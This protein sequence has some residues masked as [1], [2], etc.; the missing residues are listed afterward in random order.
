MITQL[1]SDQIQL[2]KNVR[3]RYL[4]R[5]FACE[6]N[7]NKAKAMIDFIY[8]LAK[9]PNPIKIILDSPL[10]LQWGANLLKNK[11]AQV[12][13]QVGAQVGD[14]VETQVRA[15]VRAQVGDQKLKYFDFAYNA[16]T[17]DLNWIAFYDYFEQLKIVHHSLFHEYKSLID[18]N[19]F[20]NIEF[21]KVCLICRPPKYIKRDAQNRLHCENGMAIE[22]QDGWGLYYLHGRHFTKEE[23]RQFF[24]QPAT[25][26]ATKVLG[27][28]NVEQRA[29][30]IM[31]YGFEQMLEYLP[32]VK[33]IHTCFQY[34]KP[35]ETR[36]KCWLYQFDFGNLTHKLCIMPNHTDGKRY[37]ILVDPNIQTCQEAIAWHFD[38]TSEE[39][40]CI[41]ET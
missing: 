26:D 29:V 35:L 9:K 6:F 7:E 33:L 25:I 12:R 23:Y 24:P 30:I 18:A 32:N 5:F 8:K 4:L 2:M 16:D 11:G 34:L 20:M 13:A 19:I 40:K 14:Q 28:A 41:Y 3:D 38:M 17:W 39:Y 27:W 36:K 1:T 10:A 15:Q 37:Y 21:E 31:S 22:F